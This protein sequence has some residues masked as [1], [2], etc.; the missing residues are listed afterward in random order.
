MAGALSRIGRHLHHHEKE[1]MLT[2]GHRILAVN[3]WMPLDVPAIDRPLVIGDRRTFLQVDV[4]PADQVFIDFL[5]EY[6]HP[7]PNEGQQWYWL[8]QQEPGEMTLFCSFDSSVPGD[9]GAYPHGTFHNPRVAFESPR[10]KS[11]ETWSIIFL[12]GGNMP[13][14]NELYGLGNSCPL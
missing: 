14:K 10:R 9:V 3:T 2:D 13:K 1:S 8:D 7:R 12:P 4:I 11:D 5:D 6:S